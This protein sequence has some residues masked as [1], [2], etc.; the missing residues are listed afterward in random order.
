MG[1]ELRQDAVMPDRYRAPGGWTVKVV[2]LSLTPERRDGTWI[3]VRLH[4]FSITDV[5]SPQELDRYF[6]LAELE[7]V[8]RGSLRAL[9]SESVYWNQPTVPSSC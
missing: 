3:Q 9:R 6:P 5:R 8:E 7:P 4:G 1:S 2:Q